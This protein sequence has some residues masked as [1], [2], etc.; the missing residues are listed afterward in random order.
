M[1]KGNMFQGMA[2]GKVGD[3]VFYRMNGV[4]MSRVRNR[5][6][7][8]P[9]SNEQL[10]QRAVIAS[11]MKA[12]A[13]GKEIFDHSFQA[14][15][16]GEGCMRRFNSV[17]SRI[18]RNLLVNDISNG[19]TPNRCMG[20]F[21]N[22]GS[23]Y[24][25]AI[26]SIQVSEGTLVNNLFHLEPIEEQSEDEIRGYHIKIADSPE[27]DITTVND[28][29][30][31]LG[32][33]PG[34]IFTFVYFKVDKNTVSYQPNWTSSKYAKAYKTTFGWT[35]LI[36]KD[37]ISDA[38]QLNNTAFKSIF[39]Y[40]VGGE[41]VDY[42]GWGQF[43]AGGNITMPTTNIATIACIRSRNDYDLRSTE[44][45]VPASV[46]EYGISSYY[47]LQVWQ[48]MVEKIGE[49]DLILEGGDGPSLQP[50]SIN[51]DTPIIDAPVSESAVPR[52]ARH[53]GT[54]NNPE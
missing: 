27:E 52:M 17:N 21:V 7:K 32:I 16:V 28:Y 46:K 8:N 22:P 4:Q 54:R 49:S 40:E 34:D 5:T 51:Q 3:V 30:N 31:A 45:M 43:Q 29:L 18:A 47:L 24:P 9:R 38:F 13:A 10:Y 2:R 1:A 23:L 11:V 6:P 26:P 48:N 36:V 14:Y 25:V 37:N 39:D 50:V 12:Y 35:R 20:R 19:T 15:T 44:Y 41:G 53:K 33:N 42:P